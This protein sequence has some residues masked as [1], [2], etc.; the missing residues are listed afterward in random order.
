[1]FEQIKSILSKYLWEVGLRYPSLTYDGE[2]KI[3][4]DIAAKLKEL[5]LRDK[6]DDAVYLD[7]LFFKIANEGTFSKTGRKGL[8]GLKLKTLGKLNG[9]PDFVVVS[10]SVT[11][12]LEVKT[13]RGVLSSAQKAFKAWAKHYDIPYEVVTSVEEVE[14]VLAKYAILRKA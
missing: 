13:S 1:M 9:L 10:K 4:F 5:S 12:F 14:K 11:I 2:D 7:G 6:G 8:Y 3:A